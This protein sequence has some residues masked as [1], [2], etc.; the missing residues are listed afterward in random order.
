MIPA[1]NPPASEGA[2]PRFRLLSALSYCAPLLVNGVALPFFPMWLALHAF[3]DHEI[4]VILAVPMVVR[5]LVAPIVAMYADRMNERADVL[6]FSGCLSL[7][8]AIALYWTNTFWPVLIVYTIQGATFACYVPVVESI[9]ISGVRRWGL[10]YGSMR[11]WGSIAFIVSTLI[12]GELIGYW[13]GEMVLPVMTFGFVMTVVMA[14]YCPRIGPTRRRGTPV[15]ISAATG[16]SLRQPHLLA[17]L[18]GVAIQQSSHA[19]LQAFASL[20]WRDLGFSG[21]QIAVLWSAGVAAEVTVF[22]L[23]R[24]LSRRFSAWTLIRFGAAVSVCRWILFPMHWG[25]WGFFLLQCMH[26]CTYAFVHTGVQ[27]RIVASV[28]ETQESSA[29]GA[30]F[31]YNGMF[32]GLMT[33]ASGYVYALLGLASYYVMALVALTGLGLVIVAYYL[34][35][36][37][38]AS[39]GQTR[40]AA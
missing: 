16:S 21:T 9:V 2:P 34:Q 22:F 35:P 29:Q 6:L 19:V 11:V 13:G 33:I 23:S 32:M 17:L 30:Y 18:I 39:G 20:Y 36:Q 26:S 1:Q 37:S 8:T 28:Q 40:E 38:A 5:V 3:N 27:R 24:R 25:F 10:D 15:D 12:G 4:G 7:L 14:I 31:F